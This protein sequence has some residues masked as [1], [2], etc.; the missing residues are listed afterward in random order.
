MLGDLID[1]LSELPSTTGQLKLIPHHGRYGSAALVASKS[2]VVMNGEVIARWRNDCL[3]GFSRDVE[4]IR[5]LQHL[6]QV[7]CQPSTSDT[8]GIDIIVP[9]TFLMYRRVL[10]K[11]GL[12]Q[13]HPWCTED[14]FVQ[15]AWGMS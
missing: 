8:V 6:M 5:A 9:C 15:G 7:I 13:W 3:Q 11:M 1:A 10:H 12:P 2:A 14:D 4:P